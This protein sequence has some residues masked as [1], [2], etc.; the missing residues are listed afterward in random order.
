MSSWLVFSWVMRLRIVPVTLLAE[1]AEWSHM[2]EPKIG[3]PCYAWI[4]TRTTPL[5]ASHKACKRKISKF[6]QPHFRR[7]RLR[8]HT[9]IY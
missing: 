6:S 5:A 1:A 3:P 4:S 7:E 9:Q 2:G 8:I